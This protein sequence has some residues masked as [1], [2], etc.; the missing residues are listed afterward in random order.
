MKI[1]RRVPAASLA[2][3]RRP[4]ADGVVPRIERVVQAVAPE[5]EIRL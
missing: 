5:D 1:L 3:L 4:K 2:E